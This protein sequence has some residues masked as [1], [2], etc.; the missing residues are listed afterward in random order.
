M[1]MRKSFAH[2]ILTSLLA[3]LASRSPAA[4]EP[5][6]TAEAVPPPAAPAP[7]APAVLDLALGL[8][9]AIRNDENDRARSLA[10][11][12]E[13]WLCHGQPDRAAEVLTEQERGHWA[14]QAAMG[15]V[16]AAWAAL[17]EM[18]KARAWISEVKRRSDD[19]RGSGRDRVL[20]R[21]AQALAVAGEDE[22]VRTM[23]RH[24]A[25]LRDYRGEAAA[26]RAFALAQAGRTDEAFA[27]L[28]ALDGDPFY[29][30]RVWQARGYAHLA[31]LLQEKD[32]AAARAALREAWDR[33]SRVTDHQRF[34]LQLDTAEALVALGEREAV[35]QRLRAWEESLPKVES[36]PHLFAPVLA[37]AAA[38]WGRLGRKDDCARLVRRTEG[39]IRELE[40]I[41][42]PE[43]MGL[44]A[45]AWA[46]AGETERA[47]ATLR[48]AAEIAATLVNPRPRAL[49]GLRV[50]LSYDR[51]GVNCPAALAALQRV[52]KTF[53]ER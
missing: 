48:E 45:E 25:E 49:A 23:F 10:A 34:A 30:T 19:L 41:E 27:Q 15:D 38:V 43:L 6:A 40:Q 20:V 3:A 1:P 5:S 9:R 44:L 50:A 26:R 47:C 53:E 13:A 51:A 12:A 35:E 16:A 31:A 14:T 28:R 22:I 2:K 21:L 39:L 37:R 36:A 17:G 8:A 24:Y 4:A 33:A 11:V 46:A 42:H 29:D 52:A 32:A 7:E 18:E